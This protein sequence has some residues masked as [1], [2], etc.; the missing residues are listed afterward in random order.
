MRILTLLA[1][2]EALPEVV[3]LSAEIRAFNAEIDFRLRF[4]HIEI[5]EAFAVDAG[6]REALEAQLDRPGVSCVAG[7]RPLEAAASLAL[8]LERER[9]DLLVIA[10][11]G[12]LLEPGLAAAGV[13]GTK[14]AF[15]GRG[16]GSADEATDLGENPKEAIERV[17]GV[18]REIL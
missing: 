13:A 14:L 17:S 11:R 18:A 15:Y 7:E 2:P 6:L 3:G 12:P 16:R 5:E 8:L 9:P 1:G 4:L 10:G